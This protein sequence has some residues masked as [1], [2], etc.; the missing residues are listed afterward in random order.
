MKKTPL[1]KLENFVY[2]LC[3]PQPNQRKGNHLFVLSITTYLY[4]S[5]HTFCFVKVN[6]ST[7]YLTIYNK[8][9][10]LTSRNNKASKNKTNSFMIFISVWI[11]FFTII[12]HH[13]VSVSDL[14]NK[15]MGNQ[16]EYTLKSIF[17][18]FCLFYTILCRLFL[19]A[20]IIW[21]NFGLFV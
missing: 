8:I 2:F 11:K 6:I 13:T 15:Y 16:A 17:H 20:V 9:C 18:T 4:Q 7:S 5:V 1:P 3:L 19:L 14:L 12:F 10:R 21:M